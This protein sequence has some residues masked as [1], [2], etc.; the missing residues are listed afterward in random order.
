MN[1]WRDDEMNKVA[2]LS[3]KG[4]QSPEAKPLTTTE[5]QAAFFAYGIMIL[6]ALV[7]FSLEFFWGK[8]GKR[9]MTMNRLP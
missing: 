8:H 3:E 2:R 6:L 5:F 7:S 1:K 4:S 9:M